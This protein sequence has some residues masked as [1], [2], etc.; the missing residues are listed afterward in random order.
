MTTRRA[1]R[2]CLSVL[3]GWL[4]MPD[5]PPPRKKRR[6]KRRIP[7]PDAVKERTPAA[8][9]P[10]LDLAADDDLL[11]GEYDGAEEDEEREE[12]EVVTDVAPPR[13]PYR[14]RDDFLS[15]AEASFYRVL[16]NALGDRVV[17]LTKVNLADVFFVMTPAERMRYRAKINRK[18]VDF[19][20]CQ[21]GTM[22][23][24]LG[25]ELDDFSHQRQDRQARDAFVDHVFESAALPLMRVPVKYAYNTKLLQ[26]QVLADIV[27]R[28]RSLK[29]QTT[30]ASD[31]TA[32][33]SPR[34][35][36][37]PRCPRCDLPM[38]KRQVWRGPHEGR[39]LYGCR[40]YPA[41]REVI[42]LDE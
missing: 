29:G 33:P 42:Y 34:P 28:V 20:I 35:G 2:G 3:V 5:A 26:E 10:L 30:E 15:R 1:N 16:V 36:Y 31:P 17:V 39:W 6:K 19:L 21:S 41:C 11:D 22:T 9:E 18:H 12:D 7:T 13:L 38:V 23:P 4:F 32:E 8:E 25:I 24:L 40:N 37:E 27:E 14:V